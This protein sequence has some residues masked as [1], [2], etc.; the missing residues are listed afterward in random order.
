MVLPSNVS[1]PLRLPVDRRAAGFKG[2]G[3]LG[4]FL[5]RWAGGKAPPRRFARQI[6]DNGSKEA[7]LREGSSVARRPNRTRRCEKQTPTLRDAPPAAGGR[8]RALFTTHVVPDINQMPPCDL[9]G[10]LHQ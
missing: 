6:V 5:P 4:R 7:E 3:P 8:P 1:A 10:D 2:A 9:G